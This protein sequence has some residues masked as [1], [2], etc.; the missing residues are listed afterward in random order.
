MDRRTAV[1]SGRQEKILMPQ[2]AVTC[3]CVGGGGGG[4]GWG[5]GGEGYGW[6][7]SKLGPP[8]FT[9]WT[10]FTSGLKSTLL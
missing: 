10:K 7:P 8:K 6:E 4:G 3:V 2:T 5:G 9:I 1:Q